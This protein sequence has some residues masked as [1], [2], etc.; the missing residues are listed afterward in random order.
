MRWTLRGYIHATPAKPGSRFNGGNEPPTCAMATMLATAISTA[1]A[2]EGTPRVRSACSDARLCPKD[3]SEY[4][5]AEAMYHLAVQFIDE[6]K[7][8]FAF[9]LLKRAAADDDFPE[10]PLVL[11]QLNTNSDYDSCRFRR[12][13]NKQLRGQTKCSVHTT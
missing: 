10:A 8:Q 3:I 7:R 13:M 12:F 11:K 9:P 5:R 1:L 2:Q 6:A 4:G